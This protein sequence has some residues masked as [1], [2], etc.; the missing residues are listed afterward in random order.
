LKADQD[1]REFVVKA[2]FEMVQK[3][4]D[5]AELVVD[6]A[7]AGK[8]P[9]CNLNPDLGCKMCTQMEDKNATPW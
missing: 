7:E 5:G 8:L 1:Y 4:F 9:E 2:N 3:I 6:Y